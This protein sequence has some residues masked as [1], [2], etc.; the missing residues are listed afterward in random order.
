MSKYLL[1]IP[2][3]GLESPNTWGSRDSIRSMMQR[4]WNK[5]GSYIREASE[6]SKIPAVLSK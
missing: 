2:S 3:V 1:S 5:Y 6:N 4:I